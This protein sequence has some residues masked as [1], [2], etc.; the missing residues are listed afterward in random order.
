ML[1]KI[2]FKAIKTCLKSI[3]ST[4]GYDS[5]NSFSLSR[6]SSL[7]IRRSII[8]LEKNS[9]SSLTSRGIL[10]NNSVNSAVNVVICSLLLLLT[11]ASL[12]ESKPFDS[13]S[14]SI[15]SISAMKLHRAPCFFKISPKH[16]MPF[17]FLL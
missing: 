10:V 14:L 9:K 15:L 16:L 4:S 12:E 3:F 2:C 1:S 7:L 6:V 11:F 8:C 13:I 5:I 17:Q